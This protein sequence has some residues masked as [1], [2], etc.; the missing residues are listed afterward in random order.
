MTQIKVSIL[1]ACIYPLDRWNP[2]RRGGGGG[3]M[4]EWTQDT[5]DNFGMRVHETGE[6]ATS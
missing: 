5:E 3:I 6:L 1:R 2:G 4:R